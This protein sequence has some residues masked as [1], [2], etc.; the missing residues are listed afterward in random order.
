MKQGIHPDYG[1]VVFRDASTGALADV[2]TLRA[3][4]AMTMPGMVMSGNVQVVPSGTPGRYSVSGEFGMA[5]AW[6]FTLEWQGPAGSGS[7]TAVTRPAAS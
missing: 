4:A 6:Q 3:G 1:P 5:G 7:V 2:G